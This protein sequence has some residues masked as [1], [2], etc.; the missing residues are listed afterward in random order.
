MAPNRESYTKSSSSLSSVSATG[1]SSSPER[2]APDL[3]LTSSPTFKRR[4][5]FKEAARKRS[6]EKN[7]LKKLNGNS[8]KMSLLCAGKMSVDEIST[9]ETEV[10]FNESNVSITELSYD[11]SEHQKACIDTRETVVGVADTGETGETE[12]SGAVTSAS[13]AVRDQVSGDQVRSLSLELTP[14]TAPSPPESGTSLVTS[15]GFWSSVV[16]S[17]SQE[18][19]TS[20]TG[21][22]RNANLINHQLLY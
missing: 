13:S 12:M 17:P 7:K 11:T 3:I 9:S 15:P 5:S 18:T 10:S 20:P 4:T 22:A 19:V 1:S 14:A 6:L 21:S 2:G 16:T 8:N